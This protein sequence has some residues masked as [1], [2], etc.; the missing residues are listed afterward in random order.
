M[1]F[2]SN[3]RKL[4][5]SVAAAFCVAVAGGTTIQ[6]VHAEDGFYAGKTLTIV[7][8]YNAGGASDLEGRLYARFLPKYLKGH[9]NIVFKN[10]AGA[11]GLLA[12]N[13][14]GKVAAPDG[15]TASF[16]TWDP[17]VQIVGDPRLE[18]PFDKFTFVAG[19]N[20]TVV[21]FIR[22]DV[23]PGIN[24]PED[25]LKAK[26]FKVAGL[27][28]TNEYDLR[29]RL[30]IDLL[31]GRVY[32]MVT[33]FNGFAPMFKAIQQNEVQFASSSLPGYRGVVVPTMVKPGIV[34]PVFQ[35]SAIAADGSYP[36]NADV[37][38]LPSWMEL[39][40]LKY[41]KDAK[42]SGIEWDALQ[43]IDQIETTLL[44]TILMPPGA[45]KQAANELAQAFAAVAKDPEFI[46]DYRKV[47]KSDPH[48]VTGE[49]PEKIIGSLGSVDPKLVAFFKDYIAKAHQ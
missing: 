40:Q 41:G 38:D 36:R 16:F 49:G 33:G 27:S 7:N 45:P 46:A 23:T 48:L 11:G 5:V 47:I 28:D 20:S 26:D 30:S 15:L 9:P 31:L 43:I 25:F 3:F 35:Y 29:H 2:G 21:A 10:Q 12:F 34:V 24:K 32:R 19:S 39:Y 1:K 17:V 37:P 18:V 13:W 14:L 6:P 8:N 42:P 4:T 44:R 22:K